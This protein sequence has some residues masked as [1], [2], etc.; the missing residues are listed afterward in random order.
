MKQRGNSATNSNPQRQRG[1]TLQATEIMLRLDASALADAAGYISHTC[2]ALRPIKKS[3]VVISR[4][5]LMS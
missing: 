5:R 1:R 3:R 2:H 4:S